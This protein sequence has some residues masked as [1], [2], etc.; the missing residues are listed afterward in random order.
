MLRA[1]QTRCRGRPGAAA[2][3]YAKEIPHGEGEQRVGWPGKKPGTRR[4]NQGKRRAENARS[5][6]ACCATTGGGEHN[7][8][9]TGTRSRTRTKRGRDT[10]GQLPVSCEACGN[11]T[12][13]RTRARVEARRGDAKA[14]KGKK[15][16]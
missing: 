10:I 16:G 13:A 15:S 2:G 9:F 14:A 3:N 6:L 8:E 11:L 4:E 5:R 7:T 1:F 12:R